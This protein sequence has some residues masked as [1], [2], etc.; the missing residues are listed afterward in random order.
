MSDRRD[1]IEVPKEDSV[2]EVEYV[3]DDLPGNDDDRQVDEADCESR[4]VVPVDR[5]DTSA[6]HEQ[7]FGEA[8]IHD[9]S[10]LS[11]DGG[12]VEKI[13]AITC[14]NVDGV[15]QLKGNLISSLQEGFRGG[16]SRKGV[17]VEM[18]GDEACTVSV[19]IIMEYGKSA[20]R[21][22]QE[23]HD[24]VSAAITTMTGL[25]VSAVN[26]R[27]TNVMSRAEMES[28]RRPKTEE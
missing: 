19:A 27:I 22:F 24:S 9:E 4:I 6:G 28:G 26:V 23:I 12:V 1:T 8:S 21:I 3:L 7:P 13:V 17:S 20:T 10:T 11:I 25:K 18:S 16:E 14:R 5:D 15:L 2:V